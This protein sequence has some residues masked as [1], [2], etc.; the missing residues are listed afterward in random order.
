MFSTNNCWNEK[1]NLKSLNLCMR[2]LALLVIILLSASCKK[3]Q[4]D[5]VLKGTVSDLTF[6]QNLTGASIK[7]YQVPV[8]TTQQ[9]LLGTAT[10]GEDGN[11][12]F[13]FP[14]DKMEKYIIEI[15]K[16]NYFSISKEVFF[17]SLTIEEDNIRDFSTNAKAWVKLTFF[18]SSPLS[19]DQLNYIKQ[20]GKE[21]CSECCSDAEQILYGAVNTSI[22][23]VNNADTEYSYFYWVLG[24]ANQGLKSAYT[25]A[26]DTVEIS[27]TY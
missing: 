5:F 10:I 27:L 13:T 21:G 18:N 14:R 23:C 1:I 17:S 6:S 24:T 2:Y 3:G 22:Y 7:L 12:K 16:Q 25:T 4:A 26:F 9:K 20:A 19:S 8:G 15:T 11:Y